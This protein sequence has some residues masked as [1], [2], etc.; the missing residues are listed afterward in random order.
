MDKIKVAIDPT[1]RQEY[2][3]K[4]LALDGLSDIPEDTNAAYCSI[5]LTLTPEKLKPFLKS[6]QNILM[7]NVLKPARI[8]TY[9]PGTAKYSPD[10][11][12]KSLPREVYRA[13]SAKIASARFFTG[14]NVLPSNGFG[15]ESEKARILNRIAVTLMDQNIRVSRMQPNRTIYLSYHNFQ[16]QAEQ[17]IPIFQILQEFE[18]GM[19][20]DSN[21]LPILIGFPKNGNKPVDLENK[22]Y[23]EF[24]N[25]QYH[26][27]GTTPIIKLKAENP[28]LFYETTA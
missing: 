11:N 17:F 25:L 7:N 20:F 23:Q 14:H 2:I 24:P 28:K 3:A 4:L 16:E 13:D 1:Q 21:G 15:A 19:G 9:D 12:L 6:R 10:T 5:S 18:P 8:T 22:I 27:N 26:Y